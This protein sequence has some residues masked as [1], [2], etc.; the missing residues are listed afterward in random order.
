MGLNMQTDFTA[1]NRSQSRSR[2]KYFPTYVPKCQ[3]SKSRVKHYFGSPEL[4]DATKMNKL[5]NI[6]QSAVKLYWK[7]IFLGKII[8]L[9]CDRFDEGEFYCDR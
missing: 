8:S 1:F 2:T 6:D 5:F 3:T 4:K 7:K 9:M